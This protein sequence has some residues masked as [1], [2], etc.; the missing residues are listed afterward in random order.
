MSVK[1]IAQNGVNAALRPF[2]VQVVA[3]FSADPGVKS[4]VSARQTIVG[5]RREGLAVRDYIDKHNAQ[6]GATA[7]A[8]EAMLRL[9]ELDQADTVCEIGPGTGRY[10]ELVISALH[11][12]VYEMYETAADWLPHLRKLP[13]ARIMPA[14]GRTLSQTKPE[15]VD[16]VHANK[17]FVYLPL[18][19]TIRYLEEMARVVRP[20]GVMA[21]DIVTEDCMDEAVIKTWVANNSVIY[22]M[23]P[24]QW[25]IDLLD[26]HGLLF[27]GSSFSPLSD[28]RTE[29]LVFRKK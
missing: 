25:T 23:I 2:R 22:S 5:A 10:A 13:A 8:V 18:V 16:L 29:L 9:A 17:V 19:S 6:P 20:G 14:D 3:G 15:S 1:A 7:A 11:P 28:G 4:F 12:A 21:F 26:R 24:K 27:L